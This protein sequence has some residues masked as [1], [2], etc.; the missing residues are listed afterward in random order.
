MKKLLLLVCLA[1]FVSAEEIIVNLGETRTISD[2]VFEKDSTSDFVIKNYGFLIL[3]NCTFRDNSLGS[4]QNEAI[5]SSEKIIAPIVNYGDLSVSNCK[6]IN[7]F[8]WN[9]ALTNKFEAQAAAGAI[10]NFGNL[11]LSDNNTFEGNSYQEG[12]F[13]VIKNDYIN[14]FEYIGNDMIFNAGNIEIL[15]TVENKEQRN[16][17]DLQIDVVLFENIVKDKAEFLVRT[18]KS[19]PIRITILSNL[20]EVVFS[21]EKQVQ[22]EQIIVWNLTNQ[23]GNKVAAGNYIVKVETNGFIK[24]MILGVQR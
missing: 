13:V 17:P 22:N 9:T 15:R 21:T 1:F 20:S 7:N 19:A 14:Q 4:K 24:H 5:L 3:E 12:R 23:A 10:V 6:F 8:S 2:L 18:N 16:D 11:N